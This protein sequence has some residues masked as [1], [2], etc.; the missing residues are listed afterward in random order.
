M[1]KTQPASTTKLYDDEKE[2]EA[3]IDN[4]SDTEDGVDSLPNASKSL[5]RTPASYVFDCLHFSIA[6]GL[7]EACVIAVLTL[8]PTTGSIGSM[9]SGTLYFTFAFTNLVSPAIIYAIS[10]KWAF[11]AGMFGYELYIIAYAL[12]PNVTDALVIP[13]SAISG[14]GAACIWAAYGAYITAIAAEH[15]QL[16]GKEQG[17]S[18]GLFNGTFGFIFQSSLFLGQ[19]VSSVTMSQTDEEQSE[20]DSAIDPLLFIIFVVVAGIGSVLSIFLR[21]NLH[22]VSSRFSKVVVVPEVVPG[23]IVAPSDVAERSSSSGLY[24]RARQSNGDR[25]SKDDVTIAPPNGRDDDESSFSAEEFSAK[26]LLFK[27]VTHFL[28][29]ARL[30]W[31]TLS[32]IAF[33]LTSAFQNGLFV[34]AVVAPYLG[35]DNIGYTFCCNYAVAALWSFPLGWLSDK[36][37]RTPGMVF[38]YLATLIVGIVCLAHTFV[39][40]DFVA[41]FALSALLGISQGTWNTLNAA[42][43]SEYFED[44]PESAFGNLKFWSGIST[45]IAFYVYPYMTLMEV[46]WLIIAIQTA[47]VVGYLVA[48]RIEHK[49]SPE[50]T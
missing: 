2:I 40:D 20:T 24:V 3:V 5:K 18:M 43:F 50:Q 45:A 48:A 13:A 29:D 46:S 47:G 1:N 27:V 12:V 39:N 10:P 44:T 17:S 9:S 16:K 30:Q 21:G 11:V 32:N 42:V 49:R 19:L 36:Y 34:S 25:Q 28:T 4:S 8:A 26:S 15:A 38:A 37:G 22:L 31:L 14:V 7:L 6:F 33:G 35:N 23:S 41:I